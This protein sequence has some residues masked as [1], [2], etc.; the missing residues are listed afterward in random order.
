MQI[1][2]NILVAIVMAYVSFTNY[3]AT[4]ISHWLGTTPDTYLTTEY[5]AETAPELTPLSSDTRLIP[6]I[7]LRSSAYQQ[8]ALGSLGTV[9]GATTV[10]PLEALVNIFCTFTT[11]D[12]IRTTT[13]T[14]FFVS[15]DGVILTNAHVAQYLLLANADQSGN[16]E[17]TIRTGNP[18]ITRYQADLLYLPPAWITKNANLINVA[19]PMGTGE[20]DYALLYITASATSAP[21]PAHFPAL[22]IDTEPLPLRSIGSPVVAAGYP[23][24]NLRTEG[25]NTVLVP[26][27]AGTQISELYT[28]GSNLADVFSIRGTA[29]GAEGASGGPVVNASGEVIGLIVTR[30]DD[31][32][33][34]PGS[35]RAITLS[36]IDRTI[37][38]ETGFSLR[39][40]IGGNLPFRAEVFRTTMTPFLLTLLEREQ[41]RQ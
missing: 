14:G 15:D 35:L 21:L 24:A 27:R 17:C 7:L 19:V 16:A 28:F 2:V 11:R 9:R 1:V 33:D 38:Q 8:A 6:D 41:Q 22:G 12:H 13:G 40:N 26:Q 10:N 39:Q 32:T 5:P 25:P 4:E 29:V 34:G 31:A 37:T 23:A 20:R 18:A 36:H 3:L 30:G